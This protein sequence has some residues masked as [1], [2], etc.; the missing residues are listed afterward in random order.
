MNGM[1]EGLLILSK[2]AGD[3]I[4]ERRLL[5]INKAAKRVFEKI[6]VHK[7]Q[8]QVFQT[9]TTISSQDSGLFYQNK[10]FKLMT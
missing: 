6:K 10:V 1:H 5:F 4:G 3:L 9:P 8:P 2:P 7:E